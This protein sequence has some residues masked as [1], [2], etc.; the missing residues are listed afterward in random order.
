M[1]V[2]D[3]SR[4]SIASI[5]ERAPLEVIE[6]IPVF[7]KPDA[8]TSN[9]ARIAEDH[10]RETGRTGENPFI[11][12]DLWE[13]SEASTAALLR[14]Y[15]R[16]GDRVLDVGVGLGRLFEGFPEQVRY[17]M[18]IS[19]P[20][21]RVAK[22]KGIEVCLSRIEDMPY[23]AEAFDVVVCTDVLEHVLDLN[24][25]VSRVLGPLKRGGFLIVRVPYREHLAP[26]LHPDY[27]YRYA[28]LRNFDEFSL[29]LVFE[30]VFETRVIEHTTVGRSLDPA[31]I[32]YPLPIGNRIFAGAVRLIAKLA[33]PLGKLLSARLFTPVEINMVIQRAR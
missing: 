20:Y 27:P 12:R 19:L 18:D 22:D 8:Y 16:T 5:Y 11:A 29:A 21:L 26:Y 13:A 25:C 9:Y 30:R 17:G 14:K 6:G 33:P 24:L 4:R 2:S 31:R 1:S 15:V 28:H 10:L 3:A 23:R 32:K 7:S